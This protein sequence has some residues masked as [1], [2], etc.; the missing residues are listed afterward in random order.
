MCC[1]DGRVLMP[2]LPQF[3]PLCCGSALARWESP[4]SSARGCGPWVVE[5][6][7]GMCLWTRTPRHGQ[8]GSCHAHP[9][10]LDQP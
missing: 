6:C 2:P 5:C 3:P 10:L 4:V 8:Q 9:W 1:D 7:S